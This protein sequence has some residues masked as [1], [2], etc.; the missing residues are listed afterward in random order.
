MSAE[1]TSEPVREFEQRSLRSL[2]WAAAVSREGRRCL[3]VIARAI[4][5]VSADG[6]VARPA[7]TATV[8]DLSEILD[9][10]RLAPQ[11]AEAAAAFEPPDP[12]LVVRWTV[13]G[14]RLRVD[15]GLFEDP[16]AVLVRLERLSILDDES[17]RVVGFGFSD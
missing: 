13:V 17:V 9:P 14:D 5:A 4:G 11:E 8:D 3:S 7:R 16:V 15:P 12:S 2:L 6:P 1:T 10:F